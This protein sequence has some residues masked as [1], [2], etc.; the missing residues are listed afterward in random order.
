MP[1]ENATVGVAPA[2]D[3]GSDTN[4]TFSSATALGECK[5]E[6]N[7]RWPLS[8]HYPL[9]GLS[10]VK[11]N[12]QAMTIDSIPID[13]K[14]WQTGNAEHRKSKAGCTFRP[15]W[16]YSYQ[17]WWLLQIG[18]ATLC[19]KMMT[20]WVPS[21]FQISRPVNITGVTRYI[22]SSDASVI[23][24]RENNWQDPT[25][26]EGRLEDLMTNDFEL[27]G[28]GAWNP[29]FVAHFDSMPETGRRALITDSPQLIESESHAEGIPHMDVRQLWLDPISCSGLEESFGIRFDDHFEKYE[30]K[31]NLLTAESC[32]LWTSCCELSL[33]VPDNGTHFFKFSLING[34]YSLGGGFLEDTFLISTDG[35]LFH[36]SHDQR[37]SGSRFHKTLLIFALVRKSCPY[38]NST[39]IGSR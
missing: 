15:L 1:E 25:C 17:S 4:S 24:L 28:S 12:N 32:D 38:Q 19:I 39:G 10:E 23:F 8:L 35:P 13:V 14:L 30:I 37:R 27:G 18:I 3:Q 31:D 5:E 9:S 20:W 16:A 7:Y 21:D 29:T 26:S 11:Q 33:V 2:R 22:D 36:T 6:G 34:T